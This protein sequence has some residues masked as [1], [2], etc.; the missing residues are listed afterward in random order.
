MRIRERDTALIKLVEQ[1]HR[2]TK[3][4]M[5]PML[6]FKT[7]RCARTLLAGIEIMRMIAKGQMKRARENHPS[8]D[9]QF[10]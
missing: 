6:G 9:N 7:I 4:R 10:Y 3:R 2:A 5:Q 1:D 8:G